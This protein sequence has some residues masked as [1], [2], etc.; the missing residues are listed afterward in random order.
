[1][2][3]LRAMALATAVGRPPKDWPESEEWRALLDRVCTRGFE[4]PVGWWYRQ[5]RQINRL[6]FDERATI[7]VTPAWKDALGA[8]RLSRFDTSKWRV[9]VLS[10]PERFSGRN[11]V[12]AGVPIQG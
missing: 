1:M 7:L 10:F 11:L 3:L 9:G 4:E 6:T 2:G 8:A 5:I 12:L